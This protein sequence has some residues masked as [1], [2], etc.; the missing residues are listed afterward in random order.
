MLWAGAL[1]ALA[2]VEQT[3]NDLLPK[4]AAAKEEDRYAP[5]ME[6]QAFA[7]NAARPGA[8]AERAELA[9]VLAAKAT[10]PA[11]PQAAR[12]WLVRQLEHIGAAE[13]V[14]ALTTLLNGQDAELKE[15]ARR[16]LEKNPAPAATESLR[17]ALVRGGQT[18]WIVGLIHSLGERRDDY[19]LEFIKPRLESKETAQVACSALG[20]IAN[21]EAVQTLWRAQHTGVAGA[22]DGLIEAGNRL[23]LASDKATA[24]E[25]FSRLYLAG[26]PPAGGGT[27]EANRPPASNPVRSAALMG[28]AAT[29]PASC[30]P[31]I[32]DA[33]QQPQP[34][35]ESAAV[36]AATVAYGKAGVSAALAPLLPKLAP[37]A[38]VYV[39]RVLDAPEEN[40][41]IAAASDTAESVRVAALE[42]L[43]Q[44]GSAA[45]LPV[46]FQSA[47]GGAGAAQKA[48][49]AALASISGNGAGAA[50]VKL[51]GAG[52]TRSRVVAV[53][54]VASRGDASAAPALLKYAGESDLEVSAAACAALARLGTDKELDGLI[55][56]VLGGKTPCAAAALQAVASRATDKTAAAQKVIAQTQT[57]KPGQLAALFEVLAMLGG[58]EALVAVSSAAATDNEEVK[59]AA[60]RALANW[61]DF[62]ATESLLVV[63]N[64]PRVKRLHSVLAIQAIA[65]LVKSSDTEAPAARVDA[66]LAAMRAAPRD[67]ERKLLLSALGSVPDR[68]AA[69]AIK[70]YLSDPKFQKEAGLAALN[71]ADS[72]RKPDRPLARE[73]AQAVKDAALSE[74]LTR[75][76]DAILKRN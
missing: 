55:Q 6:L 71:L 76:A 38:K 34:E 3:I 16:A 50:I 41:V 4:L 67:E 69:D 14:A 28:W 64:D 36:T 24:K 75:R 33:L 52:D 8:E 37:T 65:R 61:P 40:L 31:V 1:S 23:L 48:A 12:V 35:L 62:L 17:A 2:D 43:G 53:N 21:P 72:L 46:L 9:K 66:A 56:L 5:Q 44:I 39:L 15:C 22:A 42:R 26:T 60:I 18:S 25:L 57:A 13:S 11:V 30:R 19:A 27:R 59:D 47:L 49:T 54:T 45:A 29:D 20:K 32:Q 68:K 70:S 74:A 10:D 63:A 7:L 73:L 51:A 58:K